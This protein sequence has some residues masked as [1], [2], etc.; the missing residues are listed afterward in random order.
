MLNWFKSIYF[1]RNHCQNLNDCNLRKKC[2][3]HDYSLSFCNNSVKTKGIITSSI[4][5][6]K[7]E[8]S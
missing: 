3:V 1:I 2:A 7:Y 4:P 8:L 6:G 5:M